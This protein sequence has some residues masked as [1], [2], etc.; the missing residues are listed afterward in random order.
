MIWSWGWDRGTKSWRHG[1]SKIASGDG[2]D[3]APRDKLVVAAREGSGA[4]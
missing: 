4:V 2:H 3:E 1:E